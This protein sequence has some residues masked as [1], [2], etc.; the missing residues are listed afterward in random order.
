[1]ENGLE[2]QEREQETNAEADA[3]WTRQS[4]GRAMNGSKEGELITNGK[5]IFLFG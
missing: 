5:S 3:A 1:M 2:G 4:S